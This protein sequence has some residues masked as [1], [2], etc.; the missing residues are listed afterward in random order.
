MAVYE[1]S[2][3]LIECTSLFQGRCRWRNL[4]NIDQKDVIKESQQHVVA[5][6]ENSS[7]VIFV[8]TFTSQDNIQS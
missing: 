5:N 2:S 3:K 4:Y 8:G 6:D 1:R 7:T